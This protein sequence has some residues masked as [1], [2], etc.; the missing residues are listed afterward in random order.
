MEIIRLPE[1]DEEIGLDVDLILDEFKL[2]SEEFQCIIC[3]NLVYNPITCNKCQSFFCKKCI[4]K[5]LQT[6]L[7]CPNRC[8]FVEEPFNRK[9][10]ILLNK[11]KLKCGYSKKGCKKIIT[12]EHYNFHYEI[13]E[14]GRYQCSNSKCN[15]KLNFSHSF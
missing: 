8:K 2:Y 9:L 4:V 13:C 11:I 5:W 15:D 10:A 12:Y 7:S 14:Y 6:S 1:K 3:S